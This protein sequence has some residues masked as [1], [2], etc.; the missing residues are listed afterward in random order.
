MIMLFLPQT[1][2]IM[3]NYNILAA[4]VVKDDNVKDVGGN[5]IWIYDKIP[6]K[7]TSSFRHNITE[8]NRKQTKK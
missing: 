1:K 4:A 3:T 5:K 8:F 7:V 2:T 6:L